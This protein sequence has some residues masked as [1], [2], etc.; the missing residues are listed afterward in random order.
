MKDP[1]EDRVPYSYDDI[2]PER[3]LHA[4]DLDGHIV[5][6]T[7]TEAWGEYIQNPKQKRKKERGDLCGVLAF[8]GTKREYVMS[9]QNAWILKALWGKD[10][11]A[12]VGKRI[13]ISSVADASGFTDHN[14]RILFVGSPDVD[15]D[16]AFT[17]PGGQALTFR[18]T[19]P[20]TQ[21]VT[22]PSVDPLTGEVAA[23][24]ATAAPQPASGADTPD[25]TD[26][27]SDTDLAEVNALS[28]PAEETAQPVAEKKE[29]PPTVASDAA[30]HAIE[31]HGFAVGPAEREPA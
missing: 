9:K 4:P 14:T 6:L 3:F 5:T 11:A 21:T 15:N 31:S 12:Y 26:D 7:I 10:P 20:G 28:E 1:T 16:L 17:L 13:T 24:A 25:V 29:S 23:D 27:A 30:R 18:K 2:F 19:I 22:E 8:R